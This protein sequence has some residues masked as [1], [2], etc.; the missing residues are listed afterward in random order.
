MWSRN[1][2]PKAAHGFSSCNGILHQEQEQDRHKPGCTALQPELWSRSFLSGRPDFFK[3]SSLLCCILWQWDTEATCQPNGRVSGLLEDPQKEAC[4][5]YP[6]M[7]WFTTVTFR[8]LQRSHCSNK[9]LSHEGTWG[10]S[11]WAAASHAGAQS[12]SWGLLTFARVDLTS[13]WFFHEACCFLL[14]SERVALQ[15]CNPF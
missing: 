11:P 8:R 7:C 15:K 12:H 9:P 10:W 13:R 5:T 3:N 14:S 6:G 4:P 2:L 1:V